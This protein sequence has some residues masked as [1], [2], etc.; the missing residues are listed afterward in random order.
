MFE[1]DQLKIIKFLLAVNCNGCFI[2]LGSWLHGKSSWSGTG[3]SDPLLIIFVVRFLAF[4]DV[5][6]V[7]VSF[8]DVAQKLNQWEL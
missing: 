1:V 5:G 6:M 8:F 2:P 3:G 4:H 7:F